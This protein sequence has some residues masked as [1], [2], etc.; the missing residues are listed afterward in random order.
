MKDLFD[1]VFIHMGN[2]FIQEMKYEFDYRHM[3]MM[4]KPQNGFWGSK[5]TPGEKYKSSWDRFNS[6]NNVKH[7]QGKYVL[8]K[9]KKCAQIL[10]LDDLSKLDDKYINKRIMESSLEIQEK[11]F[12]TK[13]TDSEFFEL[14]MKYNMMSLSTTEK[15]L[16][17]PNILTDFKGVY[18]TEEALEGVF[19]QAF[20]YWDVESIVIFDTSIVEEY[21][22]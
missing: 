2:D 6:I 3:I 16:N 5:Y 11:L 22:E 1:I 9:L 10:V 18:L 7:N 17:W 4:N 13:S 12:K 21:K 15:L 19:G 20:R 8:F 14:L